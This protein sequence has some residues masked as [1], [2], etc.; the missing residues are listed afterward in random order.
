MHSQLLE[1]W[2]R[3]P[4]RTK[5]PMKL[6]NAMI[7]FFKSQAVSVPHGS[8]TVRRETVPVEKDNVDIGGAQ[9]IALLQNARSFVHERIDA[10]LH[11]LIGRD[12]ALR[13]AGFFTPFPE[14]D[15]YS[16]IRFSA[17][18]FIILVPTRASL[19]A[20]S[21]QFTQ[22]VFGEGLPDIRIL[23]VILLADAP[24]DIKASKVAGGQRPHRHAKVEQ[25][26]VYGFDA[27]SFFHEKLSLASVW[28]K[29]AVAN[30]TH[31]IPDENTDLPQLF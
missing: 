2:C 25:S 13:N 22:L 24:A 20:E 28:T 31:A 11:N 10:P 1:Q 30:E 18:L 19:L 8:A 12:G 5:L 6:G 21:P 27:G 7:N 23:L 14:Q 29:Y 15:W 26:L 16:R 17:A 4:E 3:F 9:R